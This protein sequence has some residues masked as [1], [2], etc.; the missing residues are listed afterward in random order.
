[1]S[2]KKRIMV[3]RDA[4][5]EAMRKAGQLRQVQRDLP[6]ML[7][8]VKRASQEQA[9][10]DRQ[11]FEARQQELTTKLASLS[12]YAREIEASTTQRLVTATAAI[13]SEAKRA[14]ESLKAE[15]RQLI[16]QQNQRFT[17]AL[18][19]ERDERK[20]DVD[21]LRRQLDKVNAAK[22]DAVAVARTLVAD[23]RILHDAIDSTLPHERYAP[24]GL[25]PLAS[26]LAGAE[27][28]VAAGYGEAAISTAQQLLVDLTQ[29]RAEIE[30][31][32]AE[33]RA[34]HLTAV[35]VVRALIEQIS[36]SRHVDVVDDEAGLSADLD[37][38]FWSGGELSKI[39]V[40][41]DA[42]RARLDD[43]A[44]PPSLAGLADISERTVAALYE[45]LA[46]VTALA[47]ERQWASQVRVNVAAQVVE[48]LEAIAPYDLYGEP[49]FAGD[50]Q[51]SA[52]YSKLRSEDS[53]E[54]VIEVAPDETGK[55]CVVRVL[56]YDAG[57]TSEYQ[58]DARARAISEA[59]GA[60]G[61]SGSPDVEPGE[62][63][64]V[65]QDFAQLRRRP[66]SGAVQSRA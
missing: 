19:A 56:S 5:N 24:R 6:E 23:A 3:D 14:G 34:A 54:I 36:G 1:V 32:D 57:T 9:A 26:K 55:S 17:A 27:A 12:A 43:E 62:P 63:E 37:V 40:Q 7:D 51:R 66:P 25:A 52:F 13:M 22:A 59:I 47:Q 42:L 46:L 33:W 49:V 39:S 28:S 29:L 18:D 2:G 16:E 48:E 4:W 8:A 44:D 11:E 10:R 35:T 20:H 45:E 41:A 65:Y 53:S 21:K 60:A 30:L 38:D 31:R 58:R 64:A 61:P 50:D 15:T